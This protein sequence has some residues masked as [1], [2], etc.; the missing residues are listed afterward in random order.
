MELE[1]KVIELIRAN[2]E[3]RY[4]VTPASDVRR[5]LGVDSFGVIMIA[6]AI[7]DAFG[8]T[9]TDDEISKLATVSDIVNFLRPKCLHHKASQ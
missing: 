1:Q 2:I 5:D 9:V 6:N 7:E 3:R 8:V 4:T